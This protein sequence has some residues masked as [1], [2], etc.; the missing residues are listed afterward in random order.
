MILSVAVLVSHLAGAPPLS[1]YQPEPAE[2]QRARRLMLSRPGECVALTHF[3]LQRKEA[4]PAS[5]FNSRQELDKLEQAKRYRTRGQTFTAW[6]LQALCQANDGQLLTA[7]ASINKAIALARQQRQPDALV[8]ALLI[9]TKLA[10]ATDHTAQ[11]QSLLDEAKSVSLP[12]GDGLIGDLQLLQ[13]TVLM[14]RHRYDEA[15]QLYEQVRL[16]ALQQDDMLR[17]SWANFLLGDYYLQLQ[18]DELALSHFLETLDVLGDR[19]QFYVKALAAKKTAAI[20]AALGQNDKAL[21]FANQS[22]TEFEQLGN[23]PLL[24]SSLINLGRVTRAGDDANLALVYFFNALDLVKIQG[25]AKLMAQLYLEL[26]QSYSDLGN[27]KEARHYLNLA[28]SGFEHTDDLPRQT[29]TLIQLGKMYL[30]QHEYGVALLHLE[31]AKATAE[32]LDDVLRL[33]ESHRWLSRLFEQSGNMAAALTH[34]KAL[35]A[36]FKRAT[37]VNRLLT[38]S[39]VQDNEQQLQQ[40]RELS[41]LGRRS[42]KLQQDRERFA[43]LAAGLSLL[44]PLLLYGLLRNH[45][46]SRRLWQQ[47]QDL[48]QLLLVE[49][50]TGLPNWRQLMQRLPQEMARQQ[51]RSEQWYLSEEQAR[52]FDDKIYYMLLQVPFMSNLRERVGL[53]AASQIQLQLGE[54]LRGRLHPRARLYDLRDGQFIYAI[55]QKEVAELAPILTALER[56]FAEFPCEFELDR[57]IYTGIIGHPFLPKA[58]NA[59][60]DLRLGDV[61]YLALAAA[62]E[63]AHSTGEPAWVELVAVD[64]QQ[65]AFFTG[66]IRSCCIQGIMKGLV[67]VNSS[68]KKQQINWQALQPALPSEDSRGAV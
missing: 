35:H 67:K 22:T 42:E 62:R 16:Q 9:K 7:D 18:Q 50:A 43:L 39:L 1:S 25:D 66:D 54:Y 58:P 3:F 45:I 21:Q 38:Q 23:S 5:M 10:L 36:Y 49:P 41:E 53:A 65:A 44:S 17:Q 15:R 59:L 11:A 8:T 32:Q 30:A 51:Q 37:T 24:I 14:H 52:P 28:R 12:A 55:P 47:N 68:H 29:D 60:D 64:C 48:Q 6:Q 33:M 19:R 34:Q 13:A 2:L 20:Y 57:Q 63:L 4:R 56:M 61:L 40:E 27:T 26:G 31:R 46:R